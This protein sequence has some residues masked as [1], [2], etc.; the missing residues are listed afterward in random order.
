MNISIPNEFN[1]A[2]LT[3]TNEALE[4]KSIKTPKLDAGHVLVKIK[5]AGLCRSQLMEARG[6]RGEDKYLPHLLGHEGVGQV[7]AT[8][9]DVNKV[10]VGERVI[11]GWLKGS[12]IDTGGMVFSSVSGEQINAG[13]V[14]TFSEYTVVSENRVTPC[15]DDITDDMAVLL[16]CA[17]PTGAG[18]VLNQ[19]KPTPDDTVVLVGLGGIGLSALLML[20]HFQPKTI[21]VID[22]NPNKIALAKSLGATHGFELDDNLQNT[23]SELFPIGFD[24]AIECAGQTS[25]IELAFELINNS[26]RCIFASHPPNGEK[27]QLD[28]HALICGKRIEGSWGGGSNPDTDLVKIGR[29]LQNM[30]LP[31]EL[32]VSHRYSLTDI[33]NA[34]DDLERGAVVRAMIEFE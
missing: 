12:G 21:V 11:L 22:A 32:F 16:G 5:Q 8:G 9:P 15:P 30:T 19:A 25:S 24:I 33:N 14:T 1:A 18:I 26:G 3:K 31:T 4:I 10:K 6:H 13:P 17:L 27:I 2:V 34:F 7:I 28:P 20:L 29:I 23:L